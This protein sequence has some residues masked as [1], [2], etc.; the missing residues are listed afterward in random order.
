MNWRIFETYAETQLAPTL[1]KGDIVILRAK[2]IRTI[3][4]LWQA[5]NDL[6]NLFPPTETRNYFFA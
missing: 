4:V 3:D 5:L 6:C 2:A 1:A